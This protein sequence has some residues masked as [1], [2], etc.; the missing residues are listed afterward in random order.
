MFSYATSLHRH[1]FLGDMKSI[2]PIKKL[3]VGLLVVTLHILQLQLSPPPPSH[4]CMTE[5]QSGI[6]K[7][8]PGFAVI[9]WLWLPAR[10]CWATMV[11]IKD[12]NQQN[13]WISPRL[14]RGKR[15]VDLPKIWK[16]MKKGTQ[17]KE[18]THAHWRWLQSAG[19][20]TEYKAKNKEVKRHSNHFKQKWLDDT[21]Y[22]NRTFKLF[23]QETDGSSK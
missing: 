14:R 9:K 8:I 1:C 22:L 16:Q 19:I 7:Q 18:G 11:Q 2:Q 4:R 21:A 23:I 6:E 3:G 20:K 5:I 15:N 10:W 12:S 13:R 17:S